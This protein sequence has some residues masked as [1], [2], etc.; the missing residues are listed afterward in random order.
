[1]PRWQRTYVTACAGIIAYMLAYVVTDYAKLLHPYYFQ[2][3]REWR[4]AGRLQG[5]PS[6]YVGLW[7]WALIAAVAACGLTWIAL[8]W[9]KRP[10]GERLLGLLL[11]WT[12]SAVGL[13]AAYYTWN[14]WP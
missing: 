2:L 4:L 12:A 11:A 3:E 6:G 13:T 8:G 7:L 1:V 14:N 5:L 10:L 9:S